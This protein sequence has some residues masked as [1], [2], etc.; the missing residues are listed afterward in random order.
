MLSVLNNAKIV[1]QVQNALFQRL[2]L[3]DVI[4]FKRHDE[5]GVTPTDMPTLDKILEACPNLES[6]DLNG[7]PPALS[8]RLYQTHHSREKLPIIIDAFNTLQYP[9]A[10]HPEVSRSLIGRAQIIQNEMRDES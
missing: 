4:V 6:L 5:E 2:K 7:F 9:S 10:C 1:N 3:L 8:L